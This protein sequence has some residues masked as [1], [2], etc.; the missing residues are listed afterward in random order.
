MRGED[1]V[2]IAL[3]QL[4]TVYLPAVR[5]CGRWHMPLVDVSP[6]SVPAN[7]HSVSQCL[8]KSPAPFLEIY[9]PFLGKYQHCGLCI[10]NPT[11]PCSQH[12]C[13]L[14]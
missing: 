13:L 12:F 7:C 5:S 2:H 11:L 8:L 6:L 4:G 3:T 9:L 1:L 10:A 14:A